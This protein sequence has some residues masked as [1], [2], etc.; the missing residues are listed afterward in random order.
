MAEPQKKE[1]P[2]PTCEY[3]C[4]NC[5]IGSHERCSNPKCNCTH[6]KWNDL[7]RAQAEGK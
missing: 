7:K 1:V 6:L 2:V 3:L 5:D 4:V